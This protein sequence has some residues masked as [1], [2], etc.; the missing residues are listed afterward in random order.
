VCFSL[1]FS[2]FFLK[3]P[4]SQAVLERV[5]EERARVVAALRL[6]VGI[7]FSNDR[8]KK[9][10][11]SL[12]QLTLEGSGLEALLLA[13]GALL[14]LLELELLVEAG[15]LLLLL[16]LVLVVGALLLLLLLLVVGVLLLLLLLLLVLAVGVLL[17]LVLVVGV[18]LPR[19]QDGARLPPTREAGVHQRQT[20]EQRQQVRETR[21]IDAIRCR[22]RSESCGLPTCK[23]SHSKWAANWRRCESR[24]KSGFKTLPHLSQT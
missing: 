16:E 19:R 6:E 22:R 4:V 7:A 14:L 10:L 1:F 3:K 23:T 8:E 9:F 20:L 5:Q 11:S 21:L 2:S 13:A 18:L 12:P 17:L 24:K 15:V